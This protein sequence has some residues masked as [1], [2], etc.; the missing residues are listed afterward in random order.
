[1]TMRPVASI[2]VLVATIIPSASVAQ[3]DRG[4]LVEGSRADVV[5]FGTRRSR[6]P[7]QQALGDREAFSTNILEAQLASDV[8]NMEDE[9]TFMRGKANSVLKNARGYWEANF[10]H[11]IIFDGQRIITLGNCIQFFG[12][13]LVFHDNFIATPA[14]WGRI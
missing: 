2:L 7:R 5:I 6:P 11:G 8:R 13:F 4:L 14:A 1:M 9:L 12:A 3:N 10:D